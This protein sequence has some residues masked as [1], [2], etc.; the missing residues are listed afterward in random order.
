[1]KFPIGRALIGALSAIACVL[2]LATMVAA[3]AG[4]T[5]KLSV[6][7][8]TPGTPVTI[9]G[10]GF[11]PNEI[12][13][14]YIDAPGTY[15]DVPGPRADDQGNFT[16]AITWPGQIYDSS[17]RVNPAKPGTHQVCGDTAYPGSD[18]PVPAKACAPFLVP[19]PPP[20]PSQVN[21]PQ[22]A[23]LSLVAFG[24]LILGGIVLVL[25]T[26]KT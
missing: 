24:V 16:K 6:D 7:S 4:P 21:F 14:L 2:A 9:T 8:G 12:V 10:T 3:A 23:A 13:A 1:M 15:L 20:G 26:R 25:R 5:V 22:L 17:G 19:N 11:P 18:Q